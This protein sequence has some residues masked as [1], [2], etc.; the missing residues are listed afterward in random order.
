MKKWTKVL[1]VAMIVAFAVVA[2]AGCL[3]EEKETAPA[4][5]PE[6]TG[7]VTEDDTTEPEEQVVEEEKTLLIGY[8]TKSAT[9]TGWVILNNGAQQAA[10]D[11]GVE[12]MMIGP[13]KEND[14]AGQL[15]VVEDMINA[16]CDAIAIAPCDSAGI[17]SAVEKANQK[18]IPVIAVDTAISGGEITSYVAT[19]NYKAAAVGA[20]WMGEQLGGAGNIV[21][22]NGMVAQETGAARRDGFY[23]TI[24][25]EYP[26]INI[27]SEIA[28][29]WQAEKALAGMED[30]MQANDQIDGVFCAWD[31]GT[32]AV[33]SALEQAG[34]NDDVVLLGFDCD[35][36]ALAAMLE[37]KVEGDV[38]QFLYQI[39][40]KGIEA[41]IKAA[42][43][44]E[45]ESRIDTGTTIV[46]PETAQQFIDDNGL[47]DFMP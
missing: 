7:E 16:E 30:A 44:E 14:I 25:S 22:I 29:D 13:P 20:K 21:M 42:M 10:D 31:G 39:G 12:L 9:N 1:V 40:Y 28:A 15:G 37:N 19:D 26:D 33:L 2:F 18:G 6:D 38:A 5:E 32:I 45:V 24:I 27:V 36:N 43:G 46:T 4:T 17:V 8:A 3:P 11:Y 41:S 47:A 34:I 23:E 35:P